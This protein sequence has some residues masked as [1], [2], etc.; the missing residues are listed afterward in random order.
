MDDKTGWECLLDLCLTW[1][2]LLS[3]PYTLHSAFC[4]APVLI[5]HAIRYPYASSRCLLL[6]FRDCWRL[7]VALDCTE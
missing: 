2:T 4:T 3:V 7:R 6:V 1:H 5:L